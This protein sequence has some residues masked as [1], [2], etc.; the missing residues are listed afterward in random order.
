VGEGK[1]EEKKQRKAR[2]PALTLAPEDILQFV[3]NDDGQPSES[4]MKRNLVVKRKGK[5]DRITYAD[6]AKTL[7]LIIPRAQANQRGYINAII[8]HLKR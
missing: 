1:E 4:V 2:Q 7:G 5:D 8:A 6:V 3:M